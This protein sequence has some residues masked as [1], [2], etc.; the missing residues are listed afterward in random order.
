MLMPIITV[1]HNIVFTSWMVPIKRLL[2]L[3]D[4]SQQLPSSSETNIFSAKKCIHITH[5]IS[6]IRSLSFQFPTSA[7]SKPTPV[8]HLDARL[9]IAS[10]FKLDSY[11]LPTHY[12]PPT[13]AFCKAS[14]W[15][16]VFQY[17]RRLSLLSNIQL[18]S[19]DVLFA[20]LNK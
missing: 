4:S 10:T 14:V 1:S 18:V 11:L 7:A 20:V 6:T 2:N 8:G 17:S 3:G 19:S 9:H 5:H 12:T 13:D 16:G 15:T